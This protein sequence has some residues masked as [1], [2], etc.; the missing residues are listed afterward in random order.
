LPRVGRCSWELPVGTRRS[1]FGC[2]SSFGGEF[3]A[4]LL[5]ARD[6]VDLDGQR[7]PPGARDAGCI[8][9]CA[10][11]RE[12]KSVGERSRAAS[13]DTV[14]WSTFACGAI[15][16]CGTP[17]STAWRTRDPHRAV[18]AAADVGPAV[19]ETWQDGNGLQRLVPGCAAEGSS[20]WGGR[21]AGAG[22][23]GCVAH[24]LFLPP[25]VRGSRAVARAWQTAYGLRLRLRPR[26][27]WSG[28]RAAATGSLRV[29]GQ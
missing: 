12:R 1:R 14:D 10:L 5:R 13:L 18:H 6:A 15:R 22:D 21:A 24:G 7:S 16:R 2:S 17:R 4:D 26:A 19:P 28:S 23:V 25:R 27:G 3:G 29:S 20:P 8:R 9:R 11:Q